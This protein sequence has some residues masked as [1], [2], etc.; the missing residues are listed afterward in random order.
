MNKTAQKPSFPTF[1]PLQ[2]QI[3]GVWFPGNDPASL[4][5]SGRHLLKDISTLLALRDRCNDDYERKLLLK[6]VM[7][8][9]VSMMAAMDGL[10]QAVMTAE[11]Y[12]PPV[13]P[14][15]RGISIQEK[16]K[17]RHLWTAYSD[18]K[19]AVGDDLRV[20]RGKVCA[21]DDVSNWP[22]W[23]ELWGKVD[24]SLIAGLLEAIP[25][26][27]WHA[28]ELNICEWSVSNG[29]GRKRV[30]GGP[31]DPETMTTGDDEDVAEVPAS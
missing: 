4:L 5:V 28:S 31:I 2:S 27:F 15:Y 12:E 29:D 23:I 9:L 30:L 19:K 13:P 1:D 7:V 17:A 8:E 24:P 22:Q 20:I 18:A 10:Q 14:L 25:P 6:H 16:T 26:A 3:D 21:H 11:V